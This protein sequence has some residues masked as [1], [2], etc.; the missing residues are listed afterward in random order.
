MAFPQ[1]PTDNLYKFLALSGVA[2]LLASVLGPFGRFEQDWVAIHRIKGETDVLQ[3]RVTHHEQ[4]VQR[5]KSDMSRPDAEAASPGRREDLVTQIEASQ[6]ALELAGAELKARSDLAASIHHQTDDLFVLGG[7]GIS[8]GL[9]L[10]TAGFVLWYRR[11]QVHQDALL[12]SE[13][14]HSDDPSK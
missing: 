5:L 13:A 14:A 12:R 9:S 8:L 11:V 6:E 10:A 1:L 2:I 7:L 4:R 3:M